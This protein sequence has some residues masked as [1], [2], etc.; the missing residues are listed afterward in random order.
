[1]AQGSARRPGDRTQLPQGHDPPDV[2]EPDRPR[3]GGARRRVRG[4]DLLREIGARP[5]P[6]RS[7]DPRRDS[8]GPDRVQS[9]AAPAEHR[10]AAQR[11]AQPDARPGLH[12]A[13]RVRA[14]EG[15]SAGADDQPHQLRDVAPYFVEMIRQDLNQRCGRDLYSKGLQIYTTL[16][17]D[18]QEAAERALSNQLDAIEAGVYGKLQGHTTYREYIESKRAGEE[19]HGPFTPYLQ[20]ALLAIDAKTGAILAMIGGRDFA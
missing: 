9:T 4:D 8:Q 6:R 13:G 10:A 17:L 20:G 3:G 5:E 16:D 18:M 11:R 7:G 15:L 12:H 14:L 19:D 2:L 1:Q